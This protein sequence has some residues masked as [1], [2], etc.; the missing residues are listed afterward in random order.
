MS[1]SFAQLTKKLINARRSTAVYLSER[2]QTAESEK[3]TAVKEVQSVWGELARKDAETT[4]L[5]SMLEK[6]GYSGPIDLGGAS[7]T[8]EDPSEESDGDPDSD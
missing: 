7:D 4:L 3:E 1:T 2:L 6:L 8:D 5:Y